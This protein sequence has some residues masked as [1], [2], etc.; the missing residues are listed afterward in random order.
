MHVLRYGS[1]TKGS[2]VTQRIL[3]LSS[4]ESG[5]FQVWGIFSFQVWGF[6]FCLN[7]TKPL[8]STKT[9]AWMVAKEESLR[10]NLRHVSI[11]ISLTFLFQNIVFLMHLDHFLSNQWTKPH[12]RELILKCKFVNQED[13]V[14]TFIYS[15]MSI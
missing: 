8:I 12:S 13:K 2:Q 10:D 6:C 1:S 5:I 15:F 11:Y 7:R 9:N 4:S 14:Y 3:F